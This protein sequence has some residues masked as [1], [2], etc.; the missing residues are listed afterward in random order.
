MKSNAKTACGRCCARHALH[1][2]LLASQVSLALAQSVSYQYDEGGRLRQAT[3]ADGQTTTYTLDA[4]GNRTQLVSSQAPVI[5]AVSAASATEG[6][7]V[8]FTVTRSG[9]SGQ[10][11]SATCTPGSGT[12]IAGTDFATAGTVLTFTSTDTSKTCSV[13]STQDTIYEGNETFTLTLTAPS[14]S[15][16]LPASPAT[17]T[18]VDN[19]SAPSFVIADASVTEG[20]AS[21]TITVTKSGSTALTHAVTYATAAGTATATSDYTTISGASLSFAPGDT[22]KTFTVTIAN[23]SVYEGSEAFTANLSSPTNGATLA[24]GSATITIN[25]NDTAPSFAINDASLAENGGSLVFTV[26]KTGSTALSHSV[27]Y[28]TASGTATQGTDFTAANNTLTFAAADTSKTIS[29]PILDDSTFEGNE[30]FTASLSAATSGAAISRVTGTATIVE[31]DA[32]PPRGTVQ[33]TSTGAGVSESGGSISFSVS[34]AGG[35]F[36][37]ASVVCATQADGAVAG[38]D[39][40]A[41][42]QTLNWADGETTA[43]PCSVSIVNDGVYEAAAESFYLVL[44]SPSGVTIG[45]PAFT[46]IGIADDDAPVVG[47]VQF[48]QSSATIAEN[49]GSLVLTLTRTG[50]SGDYPAASVRCYTGSGTAFDPGDYGFATPEFVTWAA[51]D[52]SSKTCTVP[53]TNDSVL[54]PP[55]ETFSVLLMSPSNVAI[56]SPSSVAVTITDDEPIPPAAPGVPD[57]TDFQG[58]DPDVC[59]PSR[60]TSSSIPTGVGLSWRATTGTVT[61]FQLQTMGSSFGNTWDWTDAWNIPALAT[62]YENSVSPDGWMAFRVRA[63][64]VDACS[65]WA[66]ELFFTVIMP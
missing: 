61:R 12:A 7:A 50:A 26:T 32:T 39:F 45:S 30:T 51:H 43:K 17:G 2:A 8:T 33:F 29:V 34:R 58:C 18:I 41:T 24:D 49:G 9:G 21:V 59:G 63:C 15:V 37:T 36:G 19:D 11:V 23:D 38:S 31:N 57:Y 35:S 25:D 65:A 3:Y 27:T 46:I 56:A 55:T 66:A 44:S 62:H 10:T 20:T 6:S 48:T 60:D 64:N 47:T 14:G 42:S 53:I 4:A 16:T 40:V 28:A 13:A 22:S 1:G 5:L 52:S 54:E